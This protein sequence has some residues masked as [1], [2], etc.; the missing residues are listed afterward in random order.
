MQPL[1]ACGWAGALMLK[2][3]QKSCFNESASKGLA[4]PFKES[5]ACNKKTVFV[6]V[7]VSV[8][9]HMHT[10]ACACLCV[11]ACACACVCV[12]LSEKSRSMSSTFFWHQRN[13][14]SPFLMQKLRNRTNCS[15]VQT[16]FDNFLSNGTNQSALGQIL[17]ELWFSKD[18][19]NSRFFI[20]FHFVSF[21]TPRAVLASLP[22][23]MTLNLAPTIRGP[24]PVHHNSALS[25]TGL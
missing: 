11:C 1:I 16:N 6:W 9:F 19:N 3:R 5:L 24:D 2:N 17:F 15:Y 13:R 21:M 23:P 20:I 7:C 8:C 14:V 12:F 22:L 4:H 25:G 18:W 10:H